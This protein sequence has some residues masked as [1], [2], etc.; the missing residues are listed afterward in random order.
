MKVFT[1]ITICF[2]LNFNLVA[3][4]ILTKK[5]TKKISKSE[6]EA[7]YV[8]KSDKKVKHG[9]Y[10]LMGTDG[11]IRTS[12]NYVQGLK[13]G[14]W[15]KYRPNG[16]VA[17]VEHYKEGALHGPF[18][19]LHADSSGFENGSYKRGVKDGHW[20]AYE[21]D[22]LYRLMKYSK[23]YNYGIKIGKWTYYENGEVASIYDYDEDKL[24][25][26]KLIE[27][28]TNEYSIKMDSVWVTRELDQIPMYL[29][30]SLDLK[31]AI[32]LNMQYP[33][34][35][36]D[37]NIEGIVTVSFDILPDSTVENFTIEDDVGAGCGEEALRLLKSLDMRW[38]P[39]IYYEEIVTV[40]KLLPVR[41]KLE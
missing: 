26:G 25:Q 36:L 34:E 33:I 12:G 29:N 24:V 35:A 21:D 28:T 1:I 6:K 2:A 13:D 19:T 30:D 23:F 27:E 9:P 37:H 17:K 18:Q 15:I 5:V 7:Y 38:S 4:E 11:K 39:G 41:F 32:K 16:Y 10:Q 22:N 20:S 3:Q 31:S 8:L 40:K 14:K